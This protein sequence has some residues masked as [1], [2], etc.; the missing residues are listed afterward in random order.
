MTKPAIQLNEKML[1]TELVSELKLRNPH[2]A[3]RLL[4]ITLNVGLN[5]SNRDPKMPDVIQSV[6]TRI[7]GQKPVTALAKKSISNFKIREGM[8]VGYKV[9]LRGKRM[10]DFLTKFVHIVLPRVRD[11]RGISPLSVDH[12]GKMSI[13]FREYIS[14]PEIRSVVVEKLHGLEVTFTTNAGT[15]ER[16]LAMF[17]AV[18]M[19]FTK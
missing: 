18:G 15:R 11:F 14:F 10:Y 1:S 17:R 7:T 2:A 13:G 9:T 12:Q 3:P 5:A 8:A 6:L 16:G 4:K 19:P